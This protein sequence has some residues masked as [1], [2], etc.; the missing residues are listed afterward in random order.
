MQDA[1]LKFPGTSGFRRGFTLI[2]IVLVL[3]LIALIGSVLIGG[4]ASMLDESD[5]KDPEAALLTLLQTLRGQAVETGQM[6]ELE[7]LPEDKGFL[8]G[9]EGV[10]TL[11][12]REGG[13]RVVLIK[14]EFGGASL[15]AGQMEEH[16]ITRMRFYPDGSCDPARVQVRKGD[17]RRVFAIDPWTAAPLPNG[18]NPL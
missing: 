12:T 9:A 1:R 8:W 11:P 6:V 2:E 17:T 10:F 5:E 13:P 16:P 14:P 7:Q 4:A 3:M 15:I 18:D